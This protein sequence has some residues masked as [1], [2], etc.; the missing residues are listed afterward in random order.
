[1]TA[2]ITASTVSAVRIGAGRQRA[3]RKNDIFHLTIYI[4]LSDGARFYVSK[5]VYIRWILNRVSGESTSGGER[6]A[7]ERGEGRRERERGVVLFALVEIGRDSDLG[8]EM[9]GRIRGSFT[10]SPISPLICGSLEI[11]IF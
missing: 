5:A 6:S 10:H 8:L 4:Y 11:R 2:S 9:R 1:M 7:R 3:R